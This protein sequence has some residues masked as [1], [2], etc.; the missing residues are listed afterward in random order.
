MTVDTGGELEGTV[1][2]EW[3]EGV[4]ACIDTVGLAADGVACVRDGGAFVTSVPT[5]V[6][7]AARDIAPQTVHA[8]RKPSPHGDQRKGLGPLVLR[9]PRGR[10]AR[11]QRAVHQPSV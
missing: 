7:G 9:T 3:P 4:D 6:P 1:R 11:R 8:R 5:A 2:G 10:D